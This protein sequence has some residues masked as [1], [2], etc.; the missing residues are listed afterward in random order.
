[1]ASDASDYERMGERV[2]E[3]ME[4]LCM[5]LDLE[6]YDADEEEAIAQAILALTETIREAMRP[7]P[8]ESSRLSSKDE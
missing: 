7:V 3:C 5:G 2:I 4:C 8:V 1:M 6:I